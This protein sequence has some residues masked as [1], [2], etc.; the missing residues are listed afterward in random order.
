MDDGG[1]PYKS[2]KDYLDP[3]VITRLSSLEIKAKV[4]VEGFLSGLHFSPLHGQSLEFSEHLPYSPGDPL[5]LVDWKVYARSERFYLKKFHEETNMKVYMFLDISN[6]MAYG[7]PVN[8]LEYAK[9]ITASLS[10]LLLSQNDAVGLVSFNDDIVSFH[11]PVARSDFINK[12]LSEL[13]VINPSGRTDLKN[14][15]QKFSR[16]IKKRSLIIIIS[17]LFDEPRGFFKILRGFVEAKNE[18][19]LIH[20]LHR[21]ELTLPLRRNFYLKDLET[22]RRVLVNP[23]AVRRQYKKAINDYINELKT[24]SGQSMIDY[25]NITTD[26]KYDTALMNIFMKRSRG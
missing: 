24:Y 5:H 14:V 22:G 23:D 26:M 1:N 7:K 11:P 9:V 20:L 13:Q 2:K 18:V 8:K 3:V 21:D 15:L 10:Y 17:D 12:L 25:H 16:L 19:I 4:V 6:S